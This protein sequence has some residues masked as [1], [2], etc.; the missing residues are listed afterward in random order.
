MLPHNSIVVPVRAGRPRQ[1]DAMSLLYW[2]PVSLINVTAPAT[3]WQCADDKL[4]S[5][6]AIPMIINVKLIKRAV[7]FLLMK[8]TSV[9]V[10]CGC[11]TP[12]ARVYRTIYSHGGTIDDHG[13]FCPNTEIEFERV[14]LTDDEFADMIDPIRA[15]NPYVLIFTD[16]PVSDQKTILLRSVDSTTMFNFTRAGISIKGLANIAGMPRVRVIFLDPASL[17]GVNSSELPSKFPRV[18]FQPS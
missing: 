8:G 3:H 1:L 4:I 6:K 17:A 13:L 5:G 14:H 11:C 15:L 2:I 7:V 12:S 10:L 9:G 18:K 16:T